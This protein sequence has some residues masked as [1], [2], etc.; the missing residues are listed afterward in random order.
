M[1]DLR[2]V[3]IRSLTA[4]IRE[5]RLVRVGG[6]RLPG[7]TAGA[8]LRVQVQLPDGRRDWRHYSLVD[9]STAHG[10]TEAP[11]EYR[12]A[13]RL[14]SGGR[15]GS[16]YMHEAVRVGDTLQAEAPRNDFPLHESDGR[17]ILIAGGIG[18]TPLAT[19]AARRR[20][21][22]RQVRLHYAG[23]SP[24][25][26]AFVPELRALL[27]VDLELH[28][29]D[30]AGSPLDIDAVLDRCEPDSQLYVCGPKA[31]L[32]AVLSKTASRRWNKDR[33]H[34][35]LFSTVAPEASD[36]PIEVT[37]SKSGRTLTVP[38]D[39]TIL[40][41]LIDHDCDPLYECRRGECGVCAVGVIEGEVDHRDY[42]LTEADRRS[43]RV[44]QICVSR[45][46][47][48]RLVLDL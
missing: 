17:A 13:V 15:G 36:H 24:D 5:F 43:N 7:F 11:F 45:A 19:M 12:I 10:A 32:D 2:V 9:F 26:M 14:E 8:H 16:A 37:L 1:L 6:G 29:D 18:V 28:C 33:I 4:L 39:Q 46:L 35:E 23:R 22:G 30:E 31:L 41:C 21:G 34:F 44:I 27:T 42:V 47:G 20:C 25:L 40:D 48:A 3:G 38:A